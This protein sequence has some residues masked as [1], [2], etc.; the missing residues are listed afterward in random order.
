MT[1]KILLQCEHTKD[2]YQGEADYSVFFVISILLSERHERQWTAPWWRRGIY[3]N[4]YNFS[5]V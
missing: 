5:A 4:I 2:V 1:D 3:F